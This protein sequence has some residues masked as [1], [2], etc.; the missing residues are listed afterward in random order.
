[1]SI[2]TSINDDSVRASIE[3]LL[4]PGHFFV[5]G[6]G[7]LQIDRQQ[8][9]SLPW[10]LFRGHLLDESQTRA[11]K[12]FE[13]WNVCVS[14]ADGGATEPLLAVL[15]EPS[16]RVI[17]VIRSIDTYVQEPYV[18]PANVVLTR[19]ARKWVRELV[20]TYDLTA[21]GCG[22]RPVS[23]RSQ[24]FPTRDFEREVGHDLML[25]AIGSSRLP[26]TSVETPLPRFSLGHFGYFPN[27]VADGAQPMTTADDLIARGLTI[28]AL[29]LERA[30]VLELSLRTIHADEVR[31]VAERFLERWHNLGGTKAD[32]TVLWKT[33]FNHL[34]LTPYTQFVDR[35]IDLL[36]ELGRP[37]WLGAE[38]TVDLLSFMLRSLARHLTAFDLIT[39]HNQGA[40]FPDAFLND[41]LLR[42]ILPLIEQHPDLFQRRNGDSR[43]V[44]HLK[45][46][47]RRALRQGW[48]IRKE[49]EGHPVPDL[50]TSPGENRW[51]LPAPFTRIPDEQLADPR[52][53]RK[54]LFPDQP[55]EQ[56]LPD[57]ARDVLEKS[58]DDLA[59]VGCQLGSSP[60]ALESER[61]RETPTA[62]EATAELASVE[63]RELGMALYLDRPLGVFKEPAEVDR[64]PL[65]SYEAFSLT[66]AEARLQKLC[67]VPPAGG[68]GR[69]VRTR[70]QKEVSQLVT[71]LREA[72][73]KYLGFPVSRFPATRRLGCVSLV[74]ARLAAAD[75]Q[76]LRTTR[77]SLRQFLEYFDLNPLQARF[78]EVAEWV[79]T[80]RDVLAIREPH[81]VD[82]PVAESVIRP[83]LTL[84][85][86]RLQPRLVFGMRV[87]NEAS[88]RAA[89]DLYIEI[90]GI[91]LPTE[92]L[93]VLSVSTP[94]GDHD[95]RRH[96][97]TREPLQLFPCQ[98]SRAI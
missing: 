64:T 77:V 45:R 95:R 61:N 25:A 73:T 28:E 2:D 58:I 3:Q 67:G 35:L 42:A 18:T 40:N 20:A 82:V 14:P 94:D 16:E 49:Y 84:F 12:T 47:R 80:A 38:Q 59:D 91:D 88:K 81:A 39:F 50:P 17:Y 66:I 70:S 33:L 62:D 34:A 21:A 96:D 79:K 85:D 97:L 11:Q 46:L 30:K 78:P 36:R 90:T 6:K 74:D 57:R 9:A 63:L 24:Q 72:A 56:L 93:W 23:G 76:F 98:Q 51:V 5:A 53:R 37:E 86:Q 43:A 68:T 52:T 92:G 75:F 19:E 13:T 71:R 10:E 41:S 55:A 69:R 29:P 89:S 8:Q 7:R 32:L 44:D 60:S 1:L 83:V 26:I 48:L 4:R 87:P 31:V 15:F 65:L 22:R 27:A 54:T